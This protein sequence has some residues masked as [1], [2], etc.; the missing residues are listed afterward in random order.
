MK[1][2]GKDRKLDIQKIHIDKD[3][4]GGVIISYVIKGQFIEHHLN[5]TYIDCILD[6][7]KEYLLVISDEVDN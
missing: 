6:S 1:I 3:Y 4:N 2:R 7:I 5:Y